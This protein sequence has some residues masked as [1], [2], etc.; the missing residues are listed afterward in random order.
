MKFLRADNHVTF[1]GERPVD[2]NDRE[3]EST[4]IELTLPTGL[5]EKAQA[6]WNYF[7]GTAFAFEYKDQIVVTDEGLYLT[8]HGDGTADAP[9]GGPRWVCDSWEE[10][11]QM[12][13]ATYDDLKEDGML[14]DETLSPEERHIQSLNN[15]GACIKK[16][17]GTTEPVTMDFYRRVVEQ[18]KVGGYN[19]VT[20]ELALRGID[21][22]FQI[23][24]WRDGHVDSGSTRR[25]IECL[26]SR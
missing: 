22:D 9:F 12:L 10:L 6:C 8:E 2:M 21:G 11:E 18:C 1:C 23:A 26:A 5:S 3:S 4:A 20:Y 19:A 13:E 7:D 14:E 25:I 24:I 15:N 17:D 16:P